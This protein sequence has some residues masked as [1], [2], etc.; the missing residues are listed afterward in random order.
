MYLMARVWLRRLFWVAVVW[1]I[2]RGGRI[3]Y[4]GF[5]RWRSWRLV[6]ACACWPWVMGGTR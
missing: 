4:F 6:A 3:A 5:W 2:L 1:A